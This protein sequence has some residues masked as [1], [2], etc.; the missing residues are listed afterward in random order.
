MD[1][2]KCVATKAELTGCGRLI[3]PQASARGRDDGA[4]T[5]GRTHVARQA[6]RNEAHRE[7]AA[8]EFCETLIWT[9]QMLPD[10]E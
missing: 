1:A 9:V 10:C 3:I 4:G 6:T 5:P 8:A 7:T 2:L